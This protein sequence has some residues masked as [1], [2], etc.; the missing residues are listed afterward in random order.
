MLNVY[1]GDGIYNIDCK[2]LNSE[3]NVIYI[4]ESY[5]S[6]K[7][8][9]KMIFDIVN[10]ISNST[11]NNYIEYNLYTNQQTCID[12]LNL[13]ICLNWNN[14][15]CTVRYT[16]ILHKSRISS[17][18]FKTLVTEYIDEQR[19]KVEKEFNV[20]IPPQGLDKNKLSIYNISDSNIYFRKS[21]KKNNNSIMNNISKINN[22]YFPKMDNIIDLLLN[23]VV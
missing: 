10:D 9:F 16:D 13:L 2:Q 17:T 6:P 4:P 11:F 19:A 18:T 15:G 8:N 12:A 7:E 21:Y 1:N 5:Q 14:Y 22:F 23:K 20:V 3:S